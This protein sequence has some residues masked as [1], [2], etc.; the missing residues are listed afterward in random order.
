[1]SGDHRS[2][3]NQRLFAEL[4]MTRRAV[5]V[6][7]RLFQGACTAAAGATATGDIKW[8][9]LSQCWARMIGSS[10]HIRKVLEFLSL[11]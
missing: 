9:Q 3:V 7:M 2:L 5:A 11:A 4:P 1:M 8:S 10:I 6:E